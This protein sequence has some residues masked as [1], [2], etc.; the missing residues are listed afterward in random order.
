MDDYE[1]LSHTRWEYKYHGVFIP[2]CRQKGLYGKLRQHFWEV[3]HRLA[4]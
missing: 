4:A 3:L 2:K 1:S